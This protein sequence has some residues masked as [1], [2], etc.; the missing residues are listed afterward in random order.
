MFKI[1]YNPVYER[2]HERMSVLSEEKRQLIETLVEKRRTKEDNFQII[3]RTRREKKDGDVFVCTLNGFVYYYG[4]ILKANI[5]SIK[6]G[7][8]NGCILVSMFKEKTLNKSLTDFRGDYKNLIGYAPYI[9]TSQ[10]WSS[11]WFETIGSVPIT[12]EELNLDFGYFRRNFINPGG[13][14]CR[15]DESEL[16]HFPK[17][18][19]SMGITTLTGIS[20]DYRIEA[21]IDPTLLMP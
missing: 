5:K 1:D 8:F 9:I 15:Y 3:K 11:G 20:D 2:W 7:W 18:F 12:D 13:T 16:D 17:Y 4:K 21:I 14:F 10:Y 19:N 6:E